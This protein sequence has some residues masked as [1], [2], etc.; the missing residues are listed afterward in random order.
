MV[1]QWGAALSNP[2]FM[3]Q[4]QACKHFARFGAG[5]RR[6]VRRPRRGGGRL[7]AAERRIVGEALFNFSNE[8]PRSNSILRQIPARKKPPRLPGATGVAELSELSS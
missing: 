4:L 1:A 6:A 3:A 8:M 2:R 5:W 7:P